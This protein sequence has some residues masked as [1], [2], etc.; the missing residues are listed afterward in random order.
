MRWSAN[1]ADA[2]RLR[3][4]SHRVAAVL[5]HLRFFSY[6]PRKREDR[7]VFSPSNGTRGFPLLAAQAIAPCENQRKFRP[8]TKH[9][10]PSDLRIAS[11]RRI[12]NLIDAHDRCFLSCISCQRN[13]RRSLGAEAATA[14]LL[15]GQSFTR[16]LNTSSLLR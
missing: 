13:Q 9:Q 2:R 3:H 7:S 11:S 4:H 1:I 14:D 10:S 5:R 6:A 8:T 16:L 15:Y 12:S